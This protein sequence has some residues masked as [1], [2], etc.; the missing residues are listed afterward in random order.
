MALHTAPSEIKNHL[1]KQLLVP[2]IENCSA[3]WDDPYHSTSIYKLEMIQHRAARFVLNKPW[4]RSSSQQHDSI[5]DML[6]Y[7]DWPSLQD[8]R[9]VS[10]FT[11]LFKILRKLIVVP[12][13]CLP[14]L[15]PVPYTRLYHPLKLYPLTNKNQ[16]L[17]VL[18]L[19]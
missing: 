10:R 14:P 11:L 1:Y 8:R 9:T 6:K 16:C 13:H 19:T 18:F 15:V 12:D 3:I 5:T 4:M 2:S 17:Q 7:L